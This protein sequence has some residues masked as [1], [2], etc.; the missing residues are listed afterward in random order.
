MPRTRKQHANALSID[1]IE[2]HIGRRVR[3]TSVAGHPFNGVGEGTLERNDFDRT[4]STVTIRCEDGVAYSRHP[5]VEQIM[6]IE[7]IN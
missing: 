6:R 5:F 2:R 7:V 1:E 3:L 4:N